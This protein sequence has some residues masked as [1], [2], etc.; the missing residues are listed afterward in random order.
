MI[1]RDGDTAIIEHADPA[2]SVT[3]FKIGPQIGSMSDAAILEFFNLAIEVQD[4]LAAE[5]DNTVTAIPPGRPQIKYI[6]SSNQ[7]IPRGQVLRCHIEDDADGE[8]VVHVDDQE[9]SLREFG[10]MLTTHAG[11]GMRITFVPEDRLTDEPEIEVREP[12][13]LEE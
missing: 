1:T 9:L 8:L 12:Q 5:Y 10:R 13:E 2:V 3:H 11:W 6:E 4:E 7:W